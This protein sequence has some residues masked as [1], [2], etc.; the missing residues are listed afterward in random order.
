VLK[1]GLTAAACLVFSVALFAQPPAAQQGRGQRPAPDPRDMGGGRCAE[2][3]FNCADAP[4]PLPAPNTVWLEEMT[5]MDVRDAMKAGKRT[6]IV[7]T[8]GIEPNGPWLALGKHNYV[9]QSNC[10]AIARK[11]GNA[12]CA[13]IV[14]FVPEGDWTT[15]SGH[16]ASPGTITMREETFRAILED[17]ARS[18]QSHGFENIIFIGDS[19]GNQAGQKAVAETLNREWSGKTVAA[20]IPQYYDYAGVAK[21]FAEQKLIVDGKSDSMHDDPIISLNMFNTDPNTIRYE[22]RVKAGKASINGVDLSNKA[23]SA[24]LAKKIVDY[25]AT[26]TADAIRKAIAA[27]GKTATQ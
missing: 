5:W 15:R 21:Y 22:Q 3:P 14:K 27:K 18:L 4:N 8:G 12:L 1:H 16:M 17:T 23:K 11:L 25:R 13:P 2:N 26:V 20:H 7:A 19:G 9:L 24:E 6:V 10:E